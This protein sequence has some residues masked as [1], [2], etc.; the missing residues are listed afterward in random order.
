MLL[1]PDPLWLR[2]VV[3]VRVP[4]MGEIEL[5]DPLLYLRGCR[6]GVMVK[7]MD[8]GIVVSEFKLQS[9]YYVHFYSNTLGKSMNPLSYQ[10]WVKQ[11]HYFSSRR[12]A[13][14]LNNLLRLIWHLNKETNKLYLKPFNY[15]QTNDLWLV[16]K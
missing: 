11:Y 4:S 16:W 6:G 10:L 7:R 13:L 12:I 2:V 9:R 15:V 3:F 5:G 14:A 8:C 1:L